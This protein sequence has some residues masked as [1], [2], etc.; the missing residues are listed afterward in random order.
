[1]QLEAVDCEKS[2]ILPLMYFPQ[3]SQ[4]L[5]AWLQH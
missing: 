1:M 5:A 2:L 4:K 3:H